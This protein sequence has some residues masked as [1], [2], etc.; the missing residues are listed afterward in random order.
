MDEVLS[1]NPAIR[2]KR[3]WS[4]EEFNRPVS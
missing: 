1:A 3:W 4:Y 2:D